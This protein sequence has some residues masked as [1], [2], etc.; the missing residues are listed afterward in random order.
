[1]P[2]LHMRNV[3]ASS[4]ENRLHSLLAPQHDIALH[5]FRVIYY[6]VT[7]PSNRKVTVCTAPTVLGLMVTRLD[8]LGSHKLPLMPLITCHAVPDQPL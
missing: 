3:D 5:L 8:L 1:M 4:A 6:L 7:H 2:A